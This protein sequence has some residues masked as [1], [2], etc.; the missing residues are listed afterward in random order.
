[1]PGRRRCADALLVE[2]PGI[3]LEQ[4]DLSGN[5]PAEAA[6]RI[7]QLT[8]EFGERPFDLTRAPLARWC[9]IR[10]AAEHHQLLHVE[11]HLIHDGRSF[12]VF[13]EDL[14]LCYR[15]LSDG[16]APQLPPALSYERY[17]AHCES[18]AFRSK[19]AADLSWWREQLAGAELGAFTFRGL[20][21]RVGSR[22]GYQGAQ[23]RQ[24][25]PTE[26]VDRPA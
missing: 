20:A 21:R 6:R 13:L 3:T 24:Q 2:R 26:L 18:E 5:E 14:L 22:R 17:V 8:T 4:I 23:L 7:G 12:E 16:Q 11:D 9:L 25:L 1:M 19:V 15:Q 10:L